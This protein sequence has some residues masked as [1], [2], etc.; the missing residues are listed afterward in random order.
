MDSPAKYSMEELN[1]TSQLKKGSQFVAVNN[2]DRPFGV[3]YRVDEIEENRILIEGLKS[4]IDRR[5]L[6]LLAK[7]GL[8]KIINILKY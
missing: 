5:Q 1:D 4:P 8:L 7:A 6:D 3:I 2:Q